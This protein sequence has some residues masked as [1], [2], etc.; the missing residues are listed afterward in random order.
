MLARVRPRSIRTM[1]VVRQAEPRDAEAA[2]ELVRRSIT[3]SCTADHRDDADTL[4]TWLANKTSQNFVSWL[5]ND[6]K[7]CVIAEANAQLQGVGLVHRSGEIRLFYLVPEAQRQGIGRAIH[8]ALEAK[9]TEW[10]LPELTLD[11]TLSARSF[12]EALG[13]RSTGAAKPRFGVLQSFPYA[14]TLRPADDRNIAVAS[15]IA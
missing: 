13:Y 1:C 10:S 14:K 8:G 5:A 12:Y 3:Q 7:F 2:V 9:A 15:S 6:D 4:G 11:S